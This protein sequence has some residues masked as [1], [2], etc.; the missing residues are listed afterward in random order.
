MAAKKGSSVQRD[1]KLGTKAPFTAAEK[2]HVELN[3]GESNNVS[4]NFGMVF[5]WCDRLFQSVK[6][7]KTE[8]T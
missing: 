2:V 7:W 8:R 3:C 4:S 6:H 5:V 1:E